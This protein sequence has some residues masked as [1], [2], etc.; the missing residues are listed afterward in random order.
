MRILIAPDCFTGTLTAVEAAQAIAD[1]WSAVSPDDDLDLL[2][3]SDGGPGF[4]GAIGTALSGES[5]RRRVTGPLGDPVDAEFTLVD[6]TAY[7]ESAQACGLHL[8]PAG[9][10]DPGATTSAGLGELVRAAVDSGCRR[11]VIGVGGT[12]TCDGGA[13]MLGRLGGRAVTADGHTV[14]LDRGADGLR[15][16]A[17]VD[18]TVARA[19]LAGVGLVVATDVDSPLLGPRGAARGF[20]PQ[21]GADPARVEVLEALMTAWAAAVGTVQSADRALPV[22][23][24]LMLGSGAGG[25]IGFATL[26]LGG[27]RTPGVT[28]VLGATGADDRVAAADLVVTGEGALDWQSLQGKVISGIAAAALQ[29]ARPVVA[30]VGRCEIGR[31][32]WAGCGISAVYTLSDE[33]GSAESAVAQP[34]A[35]LR[36]TATRAAR[37]WS[38]PVGGTSGR[39]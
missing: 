35:W 18:L 3:M 30:L 17:A 38:R 24:A 13:G 2:P 19:A 25:G 39:V 11:I 10:R 32:E 6:E 21:K 27:Y 1:G 29:H 23:P 8:I 9:R 16:V 28:T 7:I 22:D 31:R 15:G 12:G 5:V 37:S 20:A 26:A 14:D 33:A 34:V 36:A 4:A